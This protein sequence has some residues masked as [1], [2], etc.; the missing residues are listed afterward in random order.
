KIAHYKI[1]RH[2]VACDEFPMTVTGKVQKNK[3]RDLGIEMLA[4]A[5]GQAAPVP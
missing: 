2:V 5:A 3:L 4:A 1:P